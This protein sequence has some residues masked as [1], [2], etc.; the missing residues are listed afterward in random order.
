MYPVRRT[1]LS[2]TFELTLRR[3]LGEGLDGDNEADH[4]FSSAL[5]ALITEDSSAARLDSTP[6]RRRHRGP[7]RLGGKTIFLAEIISSSRGGGLSEGESSMEDLRSL[8][9]Q[10]AVEAS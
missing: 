3:D 5:F 2:A 8:G 9:T 6:R 7:F 4:I 10:L 1:T